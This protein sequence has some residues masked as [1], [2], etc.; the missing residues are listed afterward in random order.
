MS[1]SHE[2]LLLLKSATVNRDSGFGD[3]CKEKQVDVAY[4]NAFRQFEVRK[5]EMVRTGHYYSVRPW[6]KY[7]S[8]SVA[9]EWEIQAAFFKYNNITPHWI[10]ANFDWGIENYTTGQ[11]S[12]A[13]GLIQ[14]DEADYAMPVFGITHPLSKVAA[15]SPGTHYTPYYWLTKYPQEFPPTWILLGLFTMGSTNKSKKHINSSSFI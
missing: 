14:R 3:V 6:V 2:G 15:F 10:N 4:N 9:R 1:V 11:W 5:G 13:V 7:G 12:G 8:G